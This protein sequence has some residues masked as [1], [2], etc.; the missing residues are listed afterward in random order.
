[1]CPAL[2]DAV[3]AAVDV[4]GL[5]IGATPAHSRGILDYLDSHN[6]FVTTLD[7]GQQWYR[8]HHVFQQLLESRLRTKYS[9]GR[10]AALFRAASRWC[11]GQD[12]IDEAITYSLAAGD[13][14]EAIALIE[15]QRQA[16]MNAERWQQ[17]ERWLSLVQRR[18]IDMHPQLLLL[19]AW[20]L[21]R[22]QRLAEIPAR[23]DLAEALLADRNEPV[24]TQ[25]ALQSE[26]DALR[27]QQYFDQAAAELTYQTAQRAL[28]NAPRE[29]ASTRVGW[30]GS[31][32]AP[33][34]SW[35]KA[36]N[37]HLR[38]WPTAWRKARSHTAM[39]IRA[40]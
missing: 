26:I 40:Y 10:I 15:A 3:M 21:H 9:Q 11:V 31:S 12:L 18:Q 29:Y 13:L 5:A 16:A 36:K 2:C 19:E 23:L 34:C 37:R 32:W 39:N 35:P 20:V 17:L 24:A 7:D 8:Y 6:L 33:A 38:R 30:R 14:P 27:S 4:G 25:K 28:D 22:R 1:M